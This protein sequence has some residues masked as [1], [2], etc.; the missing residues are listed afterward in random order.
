MINSK[1]LF[2][3]LSLCLTFNCGGST[4]S[5]SSTTSGSTTSGSTTSGS[6]TSG[7]S[8]SGS[9]T[10]GS[11]AA[12]SFDCD[13]CYE[14]DEST[15]TEVGVLIVGLCERLNQCD[16]DTTL[17]PCLYDINQDTDLISSAGLSSGT[18]SD[19]ESVQTAV[20]EGSVTQSLASYAACN[21][22]MP[23]ISCTEFEDASVYNAST[24]EYSNFS[25]VITSA[26]TNIFSE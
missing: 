23:S 2:L 6:T 17:T 11:S 7:S 25:D 26:C 15:K 16:N 4:S 5:S 3:I 1:S 20:D 12:E 24:Q 19:F 14:S 10:G 22:S 13:F 18:Y 8:T 9:S 21:N